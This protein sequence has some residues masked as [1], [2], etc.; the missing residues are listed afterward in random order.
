MGCLYRGRF[1]VSLDP[2]HW[3]PASSASRS[4]G[5]K[6]RFGLKPLLIWTTS[7]TLYFRDWLALPRSDGHPLPP[8]IGTIIKYDFPITPN[9]GTQWESIFIDHQKSIGPTKQ[10]L[11]KKIPA[12]CGSF[13]AACQ[14]A[15]TRRLLVMILTQRKSWVTKGSFRFMISLTKPFCK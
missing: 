2:R 11:N 15:F 5:W 8:E 4:W 1:I 9:H 14:D 7:N 3:C 12:A 10:N 13:F 6:R